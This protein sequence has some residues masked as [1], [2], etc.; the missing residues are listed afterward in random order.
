MKSRELSKYDCLLFNSHLS[1]SLILPGTNRVYYGNVF[2][3]DAI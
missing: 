1:N 2:F 3:E